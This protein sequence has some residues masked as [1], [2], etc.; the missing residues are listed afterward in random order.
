MLANNLGHGIAGAKGIYNSKVRLGNWVEDSFGEILVK[1]ARPSGATGITTTHDTYR[2][3]KNQ[4]PPARLPCKMPTVA[5]MKIRN[6]EGTPYALLFPHGSTD[7]P[8]EDQ[9]KTTKTAILT[10]EQQKY[11]MAKGSLRQRKEW[12]K[13]QD[14]RLSFKPQST[15]R[16]SNAHVRAKNFEAVGPDE[17]CAPVARFTR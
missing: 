9:F 14:I 11:S 6:K 4:P 17:I 16:L 13:Q 15:A 10:E 7:Y 1:D 5:E 3:P 2:H 12:E 8:S